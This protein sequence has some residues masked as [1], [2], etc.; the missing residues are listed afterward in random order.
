VL[1]LRVDGH[2]APVRIS[3]RR[4]GA[5]LPQLTQ[6]CGVHRTIQVIGRGRIDFLA[7]QTGDAVESGDAHRSKTVQLIGI[8]DDLPFH[9]LWF[10]RARHSGLRDRLL[11][12]RNRGLREP[13]VSLARVQ[14]DRDMQGRIGTTRHI[15]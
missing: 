4:V 10:H 3:T 11:S 9:G 1:L 6:H 2:G 13:N 8:V 15:V 12:S 7:E 5:A 14:M